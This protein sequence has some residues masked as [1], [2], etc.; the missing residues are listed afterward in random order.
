MRV[1][2][3]YGFYCCITV[4]YRLT[5]LRTSLSLMWVSMLNLE[6]SEKGKTGNQEWEEK[7]DAFTPP[8]FLLLPSLNSC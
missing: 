1:L 7:T 6:R 3:T 8:H 2:T 4:A 5:R